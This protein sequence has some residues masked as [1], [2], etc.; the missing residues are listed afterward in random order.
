MKIL[1][2]VKQNADGE[3]NPFD[4]SAYEAALQLPNA[5]VL[6]L[7]MGPQKTGELLQRLTRLGAKAAYHLCDKAFAGA[8]TLAT[9]YTLSLA[10]QHLQ[11]DYI[12][13]GRQTVDGDT[14]Q[15]GP[16]LAQLCGF[17]L[18]PYIM[19]V[20]Q[21][22]NALHTKNRSGA[23]ADL[24]A[25]A[26]LTVERS[27][28]LR[29]PS[30][31]SKPG[32]VT[33]LSAANLKADVGRCGLAGSPTQVLKTFENQNDRR[34]C[35]FI[36]P[37][38][39]PKVLQTALKKSENSL[40]AEQPSG[41]RLTNVWC[42][43]TAPLK[44]AKAICSNPQVVELQPLQPLLSFIKAQQPQVILWGSD[45]A[46]KQLSARVAAALQLG[47]CADCTRLDA[48]NGRLIM[49]RP[50]F[51]GNIIAKIKSKTLPQMATVRTVQKSACPLTVAVGAGVKVQLPA[52]QALAQK[53]GGQLAA[54][55]AVVDA[56]L[57]PYEMQ[58]GLTGKTVCPKVYLAVGISGAVHH[59]AGMRQS[60][61]VIA[62]NP[63][64]KAP[65]F[66]Y[67]DYG[68]VCDFNTLLQAFGEW[69]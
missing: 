13:C 24:P 42:I 50:A 36:L 54:S 31:L 43:G 20:T 19:R 58:V 1:V 16:E 62:V 47:L 41:E 35:R 10:V 57:L 65:V 51:G 26:L 49:Y 34:N 25:P 56:G 61:T 40:Q 60:G 53:L 18:Q 29:K 22:G 9:A 52:A 68:V 6:L 45:S 48:E 7:S 59:I 44:Y 66:N 8:D 5:E 14:G 2:C 33:L 46:S 27:Y 15:V 17:A 4:A 37:S 12:F 23:E 11:P 28:T 38:E 64:R 67:A 69:Q 21:N 63:D 32:Q 30:I 3:L 55:R 39:L